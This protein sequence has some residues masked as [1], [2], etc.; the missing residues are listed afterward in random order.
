MPK[1]RKREL[2]ELAKYYKWVQIKKRG[3]VQNCPVF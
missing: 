3:Y 1:G 2:N